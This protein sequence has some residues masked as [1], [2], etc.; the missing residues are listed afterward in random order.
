M[1]YLQYIKKELSTYLYTEKSRLPL[2]SP[3]VLGIGILFGVYYPINSYLYLFLIILVFIILLIIFNFIINKFQL[4]YYKKEKSG[5]KNIAG[6]TDIEN[7]NHNATNI[8][9]YNNNEENFKNCIYN[10]QNLENDKYHNNIE[11][12]KCSDIKLNITSH[13]YNHNTTNI[14]N[15]N[16]N[17]TNSN[18]SDNNT[19]IANNNETN[20][21]KK[22]N[23][24]NY[25][26]SAINIENTN[27]NLKINDGKIPAILKKIYTKILI[28][29]MLGFYVAQTGGILRT[30]LLVNKQ[31]IT[32]QYKKVS[33]YAD[34]DYID[35]THPIMKN[36]QRISFKNIQFINNN[37]LNF[38]KTAKMTC[39]AR[40]A[41]NIMPNDKVKVFANLNPLK[42]G[43]VPFSFNQKQYYTINNLDVAGIAFSIKKINSNNNC[44]KIQYLRRLLTRN[45]INKLGPIEGGVASAIITGDKSSISSNIREVFIKSGT[46]HIL[47][48]SGL[49]MTLISSILYIFFFKLFLYLQCF[50]LFINPKRISACITIL[51]TFFYLAISGF[52]PSANRAFI[53]TTVCLISSA[54]GRGV[55]SMRNIT[56]SALLI[57]LFDSGAL[58]S[59]SFQ[60]SFS[61]VTALI[62]FYTKYKSKFIDFININNKFFKQILVYILGSL[63]TTLVATIATIPIS[64]ATFNKFSACGILGNIIAIPLISFCI[65][66]LG[67]L[68]LIGGYKF[69][70]VISTFKASIHLLINC[71]TYISNLPLTNITIKSPHINTLYCIIIGGILLCLLITKLRHIGTL[72]IIIGINKWIIEKNPTTVILPK[73][74]VVCYVK[75][76]N[77]YSNVKYKAKNLVHAIQRNYGFD[78]T[79]KVKYYLNNK[80]YKDNTFIWTDG[81][82]M[83]TSNTSHPYC[84]IK[85]INH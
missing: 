82:Q 2:F 28:L 26:N 49:H 47:A 33:F 36:M 52:S 7:N 55:L 85:Y 10:N 54:L 58:F 6:R 69:H 19:N 83:T 70:C 61:A 45:I 35:E 27:D 17:E 43:I 8:E 59:I 12:N 23:L 16:N 78:N 75:D 39:S 68:C 13:K 56:L 50:L 79:L 38:I 20:I 42:E 25:N 84:P 81:K 37:D 18:T 53:M 62:A 40:I 77:F 48:V 74:N 73:Y 1:T 80:Q 31:F 71:L 14:E 64:I 9:N 5:S 4:K 41:Q 22:T 15:C 72:L 3:V 29:F 21:N 44:N 51:F 34:V 66:P 63:I 46:A 57:L 67:I 11:N 30:E 60:L 24:E 32:R 76:G 65:V